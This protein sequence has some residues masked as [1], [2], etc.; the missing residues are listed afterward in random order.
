M[1]IAHT[2]TVF[3]YAPLALL[4]IGLAGCAPAYMSD[5]VYAGPPQAMPLTPMPPMPEPVPPQIQAQAPMQVPVQRQRPNLP[6]TVT[7]IEARTKIVAEPLPEP[8]ATKKPSGPSVTYIPEKQT[9]PSMQTQATTPA[10]P[11]QVPFWDQGKVQVEVLDMPAEK[12]PPPSSTSL[13]PP[14]TGLG[15][16]QATPSS[17]NTS[18]NSSSQT[19]DSPVVAVLLKQA[20]NEL[21]VGKADRAATTLER[22]LRIAPNDANLWLRLAEVNEQ[23]GNKSQAASMARKALDLSPDDA[24][25]L[26]AQRLAN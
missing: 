19:S 2:K 6:P 11:V 9:A 1:L 21:S 25:R 12:A 7:P 24:T 13:V 17:Q 10:K 22:A 16:A 4:V 18:T 3:C 5:P 26:R 14:Q 8:A 15:T 23:M 20:N